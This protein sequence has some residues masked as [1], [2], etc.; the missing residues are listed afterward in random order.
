MLAERSSAH[1]RCCDPQLCTGRFQISEKDPLKVIV[2]KVVEGPHFN[3]NPR[4]SRADDRT[5]E[6][7]ES[8]SD[9]RYQ[10]KGR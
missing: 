5:P 2:K 4:H 8:S 9:L 3:F 6:H 10:Y 7:V 1:S